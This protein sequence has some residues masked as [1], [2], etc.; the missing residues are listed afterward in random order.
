MTTPLCTCRF[1][2]SDITLSL[3]DLGHQPPSN[4]YLPSA[5]AEEKAFPLHAVVCEDCHLVQLAD[6]VPADQIFTAD[7]AYFSSYSASW[8]AHAKAYADAMIDRFGLGAGSKVVEIASNDGYLLQ[9]FV[10]AG[11]QVLGVDP[12]AGCAEAARAKG[13][14]T[15]VAFFNAETATRLKSAGHGAD[16]MAAN[17]VLAHVPDI[18]SFVEGFAIL[19]ND[20]GVMTVE[21]PH[22]LNLLNLVQF[23]TIYHEHYSYLSLLAVERIFGECGLKV[24]DVEE[25]TTHGGSL[26]VYACKSNSA[27]HAEQPGVEFVRVKERVAGLNARATY[28][29]FEAKCEGV[30]EGLLAFLDAAALDGKTVAAYGAAAKGNTLLNYANVDTALIEFVCDGNP[31]KQ[32]KYLP[33]SRIPILA[34]DHIDSAQPDYVLILPWNIRAEVSAQLSHI[35][36]WGGKFVVAVPE[37]EVW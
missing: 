4:S 29:G 30:R 25:L 11:V 31:A 8:V 37:I 26:R 6:D 23:D 33:G 1:C 9:H 34:P 14:Q 3:V 16:L 18:R 19:L 28:E 10:N 24:F 36:A 15:E 2:G 13:V 5:E 12:A 35:Q 27:A 17:N 21:F 22:L 7:Y 20:D 32:G